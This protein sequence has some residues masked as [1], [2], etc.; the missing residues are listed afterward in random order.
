MSNVLAGEQ[1]RGGRMILIC[2]VIGFH[3]AYFI[4]PG[5]F[6]LF[7]VKSKSVLEIETKM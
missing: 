2:R 4:S 7:S 5:Q 3:T 1:R 6:P